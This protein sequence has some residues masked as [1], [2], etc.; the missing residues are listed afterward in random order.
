M[1]KFID[2]KEEKKKSST[3]KCEQLEMLKFVYKNIKYP[4]I[5]REKGIEG[6][7]VIRFI[8]SEEGKVINPI[9]V[10]KIGEG[11]EEEALRV[12]KRMPNW[13]PAKQDGKRVK[14]Y[15]NLPVK[16]RLE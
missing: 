2:C 15:F 4:A 14:A 5:A 7:V 9:I 16:F 3:L 11:C 10:R 1:P 13:I 8:I 6:T 12:V